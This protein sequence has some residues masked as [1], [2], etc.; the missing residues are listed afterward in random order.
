MG[1][2]RSEMTDQPVLI[3]GTTGFQNLSEEEKILL[4]SLDI[5]EEETEEE[6]L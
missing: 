1:R 5:V 6:T 3:H 2:S 4:A